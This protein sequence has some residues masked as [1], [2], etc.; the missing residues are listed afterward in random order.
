MKILLTGFQPFGEDKFN[1]TESL[2]LHFGGFS[3]PV[4][5]KK[6]F[7]RWKELYEN[8]LPDAIVMLGQAGGS[9]EIRLE[10]IAINLDDYSIPDNEGNLA[11]EE[12]IIPSAPAGYFSTLPLSQIYRILKAEDI[13]VQYS[14][15]AG[16]YICNHLF[17][18]V[19]HYLTQSEKK[20]PAGFIH[21]PPSMEFKILSRM[22]ELIQSLLEDFVKR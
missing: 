4:V 3:L 6:C 8:S 1:P 12:M 2:A 11:K 5:Q 16:T 14:L 10:R 18:Q 15:S 9:S 7:T 21:V 19:M 13:P 17:F 22:I 20:I